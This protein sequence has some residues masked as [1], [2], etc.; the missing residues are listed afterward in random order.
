MKDMLSSDDES[1]IGN[2]YKKKI[3]THKDKAES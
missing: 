2:T 1:R 3:N